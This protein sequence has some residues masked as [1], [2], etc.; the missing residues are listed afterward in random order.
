MQWSSPTHSH[1]KLQN[2]HND[3]PLNTGSNW[4]FFQS[5]LTCHWFIDGYKQECPL[6]PLLASYYF[7]MKDCMW[8]WKY[9][10]LTYEAVCLPP[11]SLISFTIFFLSSVFPHF[12]FP[13]DALLSPTAL[14]WLANMGWLWYMLLTLVS[15]SEYPLLLFNLH[16]YASNLWHDLG[17]TNSYHKYKD[18]IYQ[19]TNI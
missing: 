16:R 6:R 2:C 19:E 15:E 7:R 14:F 11:S 18:Q 13:E 10:V 3:N 5:S 12:F 1:Y 17:F 8:N 4:W 9:G